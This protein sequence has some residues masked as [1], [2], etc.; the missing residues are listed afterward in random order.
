MQD[1]KAEA[2][3]AKTKPADRKVGVFISVRKLFFFFREVFMAFLFHC[4]P[5]KVTW[6]LL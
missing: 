1:K 5:C 3:K 4:L 6:L 2:V